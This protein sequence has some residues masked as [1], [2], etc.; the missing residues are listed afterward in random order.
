MKLVLV[1]NTNIGF[2]NQSLDWIHKVISPSTYLCSLCNLT[3]TAFRVK[4]DWKSF[5]EKTNLEIEFLHKNEF[6][7]QYPT[8]KKDFPWIGLIKD[9]KNSRTIADNIILNQFENTDQ[10]LDFLK[11][12]LKMFELK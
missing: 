11:V 4:E 1:Y 6:A 12:K 8:L 5:V 7:K 2:V 3:H 9:S 10:L